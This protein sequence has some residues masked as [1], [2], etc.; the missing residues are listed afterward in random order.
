ME[1]ELF[2]SERKLVYELEHYLL[3]SALSTHIFHC[4]MLLVVEEPGDRGSG[5]AARHHALEC[6]APGRDHVGGRGG[7][8]DG[9]HRGKHW[10]QINTW[11]LRPDVIPIQMAVNGAL[12]IFRAM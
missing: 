6:P 12:F 7:A 2:S 4:S 8:R 3:T 9:H 10:G 5:V 11:I 1:D